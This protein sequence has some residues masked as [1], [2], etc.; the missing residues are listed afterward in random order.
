MPSSGKSVIVKGGAPLSGGSIGG[1][2]IGQSRG[3]M[4]SS[5]ASKSE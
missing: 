5:N 2:R 3:G 4:V 1:H